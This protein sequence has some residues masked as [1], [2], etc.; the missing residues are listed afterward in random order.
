MGLLLQCACNLRGNPMIFNIERPPFNP[1]TPLWTLLSHS[2]PTLLR[3]FHK[4]YQG[5]LHKAR[6]SQVPRKKKK[7]TA[8]KQSRPI[9]IIQPTLRRK[10]RRGGMAMTNA[11]TLGAALLAILLSVTLSTAANTA[12]T[13]AMPVEAAVT[14]HCE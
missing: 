8:M 14:A 6:Q 9:E 12:D 3:D 5:F 7:E 1:Q 2:K 11:L 4:K 10:A 13:C